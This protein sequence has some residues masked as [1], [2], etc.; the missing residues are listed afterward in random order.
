MLNNNENW[1]AVKGFENYEE[2]ALHVNYII[3]KYNLI[4]RPKNII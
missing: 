3:D 4:D 1:K 2:A